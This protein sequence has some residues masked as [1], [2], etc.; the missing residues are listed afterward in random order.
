MALVLYGQSICA[1][2]GE[3]VRKD[4]LIF[5]T[6][7]VAFPTPHPLF[8]FCDA[9]L[10]WDCYASWNRREEF[11]RAYF[12]GKIVGG[13][14]NPYWGCAYV[15]DDIYVSVN[16]REEVAEVSIVLAA[17]AE[18]IRVKLRDW[19]RWTNDEALATADLHPLQASLLLEQLPLLRHK[20]PTADAVVKAVNWA[21]K[22]ELFEKQEAER[23]ERDRQFENAENERRKQ[24]IPKNVATTELHARATQT[25]LPCPR[26][27]VL[28]RDYRIVDNRRTGRREMICRT[29]GWT[30]DA[31]LQAHF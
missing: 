23:L 29:C 25:G 7:G 20:L 24:L 30:F 31:N 13:R 27:R 16:P 21:E 19:G 18:D 2:C 26:C 15:D 10:H 5:A 12:L 8:P 11:A 9:P 17:T 6:S 1:I 22:D 4:Q 28:S 3:L 14:V